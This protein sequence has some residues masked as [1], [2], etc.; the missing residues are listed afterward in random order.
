[1]EPKTMKRVVAFLVSLAVV[2]L[3]VIWVLY[4]TRWADISTKMFSVLVPLFFGMI[5]LSLLLPHLS[6]FKIGGITAEISSKPEHFDGLKEQQIESGVTFLPVSIIA[7]D[8]VVSDPGHTG[9]APDGVVTDPGQTGS[10]K[11]ISQ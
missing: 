1:M 10:L 9:N 7:P 11:G 4:L 5:L 2:Q 3:A 8:V 6:K